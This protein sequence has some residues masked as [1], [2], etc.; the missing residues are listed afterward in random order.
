MTSNFVGPQKSPYVIFLR[1]K[2]MGEALGSLGPKDASMKISLGLQKL[3]IGY[4]KL[5]IFDGS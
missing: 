1:P 5:K 3:G 2:I 4:L